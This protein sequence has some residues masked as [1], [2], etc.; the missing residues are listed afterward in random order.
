MSGIIF[1]LLTIYNWDVKIKVS[2]VLYIPVCNWSFTV[3]TLLFIQIIIEEYR[4]HSGRNYGSGAVPCQSASIFVL[5]NICTTLE[6]H[7]Y[8]EQLP[9]TIYYQT[10][11]SLKHKNVVESYETATED[12]GCYVSITIFSLKQFLQ[13]PRINCR[14]A[15]FL[16]SPFCS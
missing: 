1:N 9:S 4:Q 11:S 2:S 10:Y 12:D 13:V 6:E 5:T 16:L 14:P 15:P 8:I 3:V 7:V